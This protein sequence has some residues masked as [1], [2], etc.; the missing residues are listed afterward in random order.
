[1]EMELEME[2]LS[3]AWRNA[4]TQSSARVSERESE[5]W[6]ASWSRRKNRTEQNRRTEQEDEDEEGRK[7]KSEEEKQNRTK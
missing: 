4:S 2:K 5:L 3:M 7:K 6:K 1:M